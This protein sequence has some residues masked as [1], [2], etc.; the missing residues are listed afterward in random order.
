MTIPPLGSVSQTLA[1]L[2]SAAPSG[3]GS[4]A[5][6]FQQAL[7]GA[8]GGIAQATSQANTLATQFA[9][10]GSGTLDAL[11]VTTAQADLAVESASTVMSKALSA[12]QTIMQMSV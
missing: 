7:S 6:G 3:A 12:Y 8:I 4:A 2:P 9:Y 11:M 5:T 10:A 1:A